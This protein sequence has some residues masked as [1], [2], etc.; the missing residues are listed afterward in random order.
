MADLGTEVGGVKDADP[1]GAMVSGR[2][3][4]A[5]AVARRYITPRGRLIDDPDYGTDLTE[6]LNADL[7]PAD[8]AR[9]FSDASREAQKDERVVGCDVT[10][11]FIGGS[12]V[13]N[14]T[15]TDGAGPFQ[16]VLVVTAVTVTLL[17]VQP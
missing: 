9:M 10:G 13:L 4:L 12:V 6:Y 16:L 11:T 5:E 7:G 17:T 3:C 15:L 8:L 1:Q 2:R 14:V